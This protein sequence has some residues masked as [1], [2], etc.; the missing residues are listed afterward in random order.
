MNRRLWFFVL[1]VFIYVFEGNID[2]SIELLIE[3]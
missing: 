3:Y 1:L 2:I